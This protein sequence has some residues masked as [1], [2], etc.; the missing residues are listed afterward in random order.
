MN[1]GSYI[2]QKILQLR[3]LSQSVGEAGDITGMRF[4]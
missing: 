2:D 1:G 4:I 3:K